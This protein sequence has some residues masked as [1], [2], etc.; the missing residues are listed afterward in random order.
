M[1]RTR[2][3]EFAKHLARTNKTFTILLNTRNI[4]SHP[5]HNTGFNTA[6]CTVQDNLAIKP[7]C[8]LPSLTKNWSGCR[9]EIWYQIDHNS[10][11][12]NVLKLFCLDVAPAGCISCFSCLRSLFGHILRVHA[13]GGKSKNTKYRKNYRTKTLQW[14]NKHM[15]SQNTACKAIFYHVYVEYQQI[16]ALTYQC[17]VTF[18]K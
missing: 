2:N 18:K 10:I 8:T 4:L 15:H 11:L 6:P 1:G 13:R 5:R 14:A 12:N 3:N 7:H 17:L 16:N 9:Y